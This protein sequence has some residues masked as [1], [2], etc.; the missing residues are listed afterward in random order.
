MKQV[1]IG[2]DPHLASWVVWHVVLELWAASAWQVKERHLVPLPGSVSG[3]ACPPSRPPTCRPG[4]SSSCTSAQGENAWITWVTCVG[5][6]IK[7]YF[8]LKYEGKKTHLKK[9]DLLIRNVELQSLVSTAWEQPCGRCHISAV[10]QGLI[11]AKPPT[12]Q[13]GASAGVPTSWSR[14][15]SAGD[16]IKGS[17]W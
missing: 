7:K 9:L 10:S 13:T 6:R 4:L 14:R 5:L 17:F 2:T 11:R 15:G 3:V 1:V 8:L 12:P 16:I